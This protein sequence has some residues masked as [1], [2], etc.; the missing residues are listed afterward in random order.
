MST[1]RISSDQVVQLLDHEYSRE[2]RRWYLSLPLLAIT[3]GDLMSSPRSAKPLAV[4]FKSVTFQLLH[5]VEFIHHA[6]IAHRDINPSN[7]MLGWDGRVVLIDFGTAWDGASV[8]DDPDE[9]EG[10]MSCAVGTG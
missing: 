8:P 6:G 2:D 7:V 9:A 3:L 1:D 5:G 4:L 10:Y